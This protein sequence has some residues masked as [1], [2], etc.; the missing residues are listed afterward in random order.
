MYYYTHNKVDYQPYTLLY[1]YTTSTCFSI[2]T[3]P[4][5]YYYV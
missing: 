4:I 1:S 2:G 3:V 5:G